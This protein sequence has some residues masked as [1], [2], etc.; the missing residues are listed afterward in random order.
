MG[1]Q[2]G[3]HTGYIVA[4]FLNTSTG[5]SIYDTFTDYEKGTNGFERAPGWKSK[6]GTQAL[7]ARSKAGH[8]DL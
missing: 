3:C 1:K 5:C 7:K 6:Q 4:H 8:R 2:I